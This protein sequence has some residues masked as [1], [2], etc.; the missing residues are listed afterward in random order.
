MERL[1]YFTNDDFKKASPPCAM[2]D[3][4][5]DFLRKLDRCRE[6][7][8]IPFIVNSAYRS[9]AW[10]K[11]HGRSGNGA[12]PRRV[13]VDIRCTD[14]R[15]RWCILLAAFSVGF[16]RIGVA[17]SFVHLDDCQ[18]LPGPVVWTYD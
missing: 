12:H 13:A 10:E 4:S 7:A 9:P 11:A 1:K 14:S 2:S 6:I 18:E 16:R 5:P 15:S 8:G 3:L 17:R